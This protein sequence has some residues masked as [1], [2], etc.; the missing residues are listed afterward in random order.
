[1]GALRHGP[2][3]GA[4]TEDAPGSVDPCRAGGKTQGLAFDDFLG[5]LARNLG[6]D[7]LTL[8]KAVVQTEQEIVDEAVAA[9]R[10][11]PEKAARIKQRVEQSGGRRFFHGRHSGPRHGPMGVVARAAAEALDVT[12]EQLKAELPG[13]TLNALA[14]KH[15]KDHNV[16]KQKI[17]DALTARVDEGGAAGYLTP[18][19]AGTI[20][21]RLSQRVELL[22]SHTF[23]QCDRSRPGGSPRVRPSA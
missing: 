4:Q 1:V 12:V 6:V 19:R 5:K 16:V 17:V 23:V 15:N 10:L 8:Q 3:K 2:G 13:T 7:E 14:A 21:A 18:E 11:K 9:G 22:M 20:K